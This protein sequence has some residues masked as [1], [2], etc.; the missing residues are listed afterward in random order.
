M[1]F[2]LRPEPVLTTRPFSDRCPRILKV[3]SFVIPVRVSTSA[4]ASVEP[5]GNELRTAFSSAVSVML[6]STGSLT[7]TVEGPTI[8]E[9]DTLSPAYSSM[10]RGMPVPN[11]SI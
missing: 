7:V 6:V 8:N 1:Y 4:L 2:V 10:M 11:R 3:F 9:G 5:F